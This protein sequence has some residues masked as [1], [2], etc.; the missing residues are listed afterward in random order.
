MNHAG[1][2]EFG[3]LYIL[4]FTG[5]EADSCSCRNI[6]SHAECRRAIERES[7]IGFKEVVVAADLDGP[8]AGVSDEQ[9]ERLSTGI[10][11]N[12]SGTFVE[13]IFPRIHGVSGLD[14]ES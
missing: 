10:R 3:E 4:F 5:L 1:A 12:R 9:A 6:E 7:A 8:V 2:S 13:K 14:R 11:K